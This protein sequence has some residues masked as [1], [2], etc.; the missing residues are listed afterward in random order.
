MPRM[1]ETVHHKANGL[2]R[3]MRRCLEAGGQCDGIDSPKKSAKRPRERILLISLRWTFCDW[4]D[5][6][7]LLSTFSFSDL[8]HRRVQHRLRG[9]RILVRADCSETKELDLCFPRRDSAAQLLS[10]T[11][12]LFTKYLPSALWNRRGT[13]APALPS[14]RPCSS[15]DL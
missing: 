12:S 8:V 6:R 10:R 2:L 15:I 3:G 14:G 4:R 5:R 1:R 13:Q 7:T 9:F 11:A